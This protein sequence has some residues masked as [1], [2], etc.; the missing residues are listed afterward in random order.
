MSGTLTFSGLKMLV[1]TQD[2]DTEVLVQDPT[3]RMVQHCTIGF[4]P[5]ERRPGRH[6]AVII[7][8][9]D[10]HRLTRQNP[11]GPDSVR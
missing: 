1:D 6:V 9:D 10:G 8:L 7:P 5:D 4:M 11:G 3:G 2:L